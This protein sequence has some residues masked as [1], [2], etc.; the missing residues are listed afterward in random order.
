M[1][2]YKRIMIFLF[3]YG[4]SWTVQNGF[5][6]HADP[7]LGWSFST[8]TSCGSVYQQLSSS[9]PVLLLLSTRW[10]V[11]KFSKSDIRMDRATLV[12]LELWAK[13]VEPLCF[14]ICVSMPVTAMTLFQKAQRNV[15]SFSQIVPTFKLYENIV[16]FLKWIRRKLEK[17]WIR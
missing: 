11:S 10:N 2:L 7:L 16:Y 4:W 14:R 12:F 3:C 17:K 13:F 15:T 1:S 8:I 9:P 5:I 6:Q